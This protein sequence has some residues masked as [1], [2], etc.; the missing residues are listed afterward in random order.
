MQLQRELT[1]NIIEGLSV[2][3][4]DAPKVHGNRISGSVVVTNQTGH[5]FD[6]TVIVVAVNQIGR[7]TAL[8]YQ[9]FTLPAGSTS[10]LIPFESSPGQGRYYVRVDAAAHRPGKKRVYRA[11]KQTPD[12]IKVQQL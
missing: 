5:D 1:I 8:G 3:W 4:Q 10:Q 9:H 2:D 12:S 11:S 7:A 6:L